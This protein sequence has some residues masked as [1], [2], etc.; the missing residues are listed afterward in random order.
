MSAKIPVPL[1]PS[2]TV[3]SDPLQDEHTSFHLCSPN[4]YNAKRTGHSQHNLLAKWTPLTESSALWTQQTNPQAIQHEQTT[5]S[6]IFILDIILP[7]IT[8]NIKKSLASHDVKV[9]SL[10]GTSRRDLLI[11]TKTT[12]PPHLILYARY[13]CSRAH[14]ALRPMPLGQAYAT[15]GYLV[16][17]VSLRTFVC[18]IPLLARR[19]RPKG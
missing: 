7:T 4:T 17:N 8:K 2:K 12:P 16:Y 14:S 13:L 1:H 5:K 15:I 9:T 19:T 3:S 11:K 18:K 10:S 6:R